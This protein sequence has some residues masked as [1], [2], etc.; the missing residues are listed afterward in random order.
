MT[1]QQAPSNP[2][3][4]GLEIAIIGMAGR[5]PGAQS[6]AEFWQNLQHSVESIVP[7]EDAQLLAQGVSPDTLADPNYV[8][9]GGVLTDPDQFDA[10]FFGFSPR[11]A[12][13]L[14]PQQR[15]FLE[16]AWEAL[17]TAGYDTERYKGSIGVY[18]GAGM[19]GYLLNL[20]AN[21]AIRETVSPYELF[22]SNDKDFLT[23]RVSY[24]LN[25]QGPSLDVQTACSSSL[26]AVHLACQGL[27]SGECDMALA[28]GVA[29][30]K[31]LGY[32]A[33]TGG[34]YA[35]DGHCRAFDA[36][37]GG[38]VGGNGV[39]M[40]V[41][42]RLEDA[43]ADGD[44]IDAVI[45]GSAINNDGALKVS[46]TAPRIDA[47]A[48]VIQAALSV[49]EVPPESIG[50][51]EA[52]GTGTDLGDPIEVAALT[53][54]F[55]T[56]QSGFCAIGSV[57]TNIGHLDAAAGIAGLIKTVLALKHRQIPASLHFQQPNPKID[58]ENSPFYVNTTLA[59]WPRKDGS[60]RAGVSSFGIG[61]TNAHVILE[62]APIPSHR[63]VLEQPQLLI[64]SAKT[65][66][67]LAAA[68]HALSRYLE[69]SPNPDLANVAYTLQVG[70][71]AFNHRRSV[72]CQ[73][74][75]EAIGQLQLPI[76]Q[77]ISQTKFEHPT[78][79]FLFP[80]QGSQYPGMAQGLYESQP[81]FRD[82]LNECATLLETDLDRPLLEIICIQGMQNKVG[83]AL[84]VQALHATPLPTTHP[85]LPPTHHPLS[86]TRYTQPALFAI[87]Y[88]LAKLWMHWGLK[89]E[90]MLG[91]SL[92]E[93]VAA[94]LAGVFDLE[95]A[96]RL[97]ALRGRL[98]QQ[99]PGGY[100]LSV[101]ISSETLQPW[102]NDEITLAASNGPQLCV[103]SGGEAEIATLQTQLEE[104]SVSC[105]R[106]HTSH[107]F[108]SPLMEPMRA[109]F[110]EAVSQVKLHPP[111]LPFISNVTGTWIT[112]EE[113]T[114][115]AYW[116][117][118]ARQTVRFSEGVTELLQLADPVLL[119]VGPG[120]TLTTL[121]RQHLAAA[122]PSSTIHSL[123]HPKAAT[124]EDADIKQLL[125]A[126]GQ[127]WSTGISIDWQVFQT[128]HRRRIPLP[129]Y[130]FERQR[131]WVDLD[132][133][134]LNEASFNL[135]AANAPQ[136]SD[137]ALA[138]DPA[139]WFYSPG[140]RRMT[141][142]KPKPLPPMERPCWLIFL[143]NLGIGEQLAKQIEQ[144]GQD[145][146]TVRSGK[147]FEQIGYRQF[148]L[149]CSQPDNYQLLLDDLQMRET[150][151]TAIVYLWSLDLDQP[152]MALLNLL[153]TWSTQ[154]DPLQVT[155]VTEAVY[156]VI[157]HETLQPE[158]S[159]IQG[160][161]QVI[162]QEYPQIGCRQIDMLAPKTSSEIS[163][164]QLAP[165]LWQDLQT[166]SPPA[167]VA[168]RGRHR[169]EQTYQAVPL[170]ERGSERGPDGFRQGGVYA[171]IGDLEQGLG[172]AWARALA[173]HYRAKLVLI[174]PVESVPAE[175]TLLLEQ[176]A[177]EVLTLLVDLAS[178]DTLQNALKQAVNEVGPIHGIFL[179]SPTTN[180]KSAAPIALLQSF[181]WHY[182]HQT[183]GQVLENL[184]IALKDVNC[185]P[186][187]CCIQSSLSSVIG[188][189]GLAA[190]AGANHMIDTLVTQQN[191]QSPFP[192]FSVNWDAWS[193]EAAETGWGSTLKDF[194]LTSQEVWTA[195]ERILTQANPG[196]IV[197][198]KG[199]LQA[200]L[201]K[202]IHATPHI[203]THDS[204]SEGSGTHSRPQLS[205]AYV[206]PRNDVEQTI[207]TIW[208]DLLGLEQVGIH[209]SFFDL[210]GHSL[211]AIQVISRLRE[212]FPV[213]LEMRNL[214]FEAPTVAGIAAMIAE[215]I[216]QTEDLDTM[217][218]LLA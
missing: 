19:N 198:S 127:L 88:A 144:A 75:T 52:H 47:Q 105:R 93:Y 25:L 155:V 153:K 56:D 134:E 24:K 7:L 28:G 152:F 169:W 146:F 179:S 214:L 178:S 78:L 18:G 64:L 67:A 39:G 138:A 208:Q 90:A 184:V 170:P 37:A 190:Y 203:D 44:T 97:V 58:F 61:G 142:S 98:M 33:Q 195:T 139:N 154:S 62:A 108:H 4:T 77:A 51:I 109:P 173:Q 103:V 196:Q 141:A 211:L 202:W 46:Y 166:V 177:T 17:E 20:Y 54:A 43:L 104:N 1:S 199:D 133:S 200:R 122:A 136:P 59:D 125:T 92:G 48:A 140:W 207:A 35:A 149:D 186:D 168:Y 10:A 158:H 9:V 106:L 55:Q 95:T 185:A 87:E 60:R 160:L 68:A 83:N 131:Y 116:G 69:R 137:I 57:K 91:H 111:T 217:A 143:D 102:I 14:D 161:C 16:T 40:V 183:K 80:G 188:G 23:T 94:C 5:F 53:Q 11:E 157:G 128:E 145:V 6:V 15:V 135:N 71:R 31:Q 176:G 100:M 42:K 101:G 32:R 74:T 167:V 156:E 22:I 107:A 212:A 85:P 150:I 118:Q 148:S 114:N 210:G 124:E 96:L 163:S 84:P 66:T 73:N 29:I 180:E 187:F 201:A 174:Q 79:I 50:Y 89:P 121:T 218:A 21:P 151:P 192:W 76:S 34:I 12:E 113:A 126:A 13:L 119:E 171:I 8:K 30:S 41:L 129:T 205:T 72:V 182:N 181:H 86:Q 110:V 193:E 70:R 164:A 3:L 65:A 194:A 197:V 189:V 172:L 81:V 147:S 215:Q 175:R 45:K 206:A 209:D 159:A 216:P 112:P 36:L 132:F 117:Q 38:T 49:A 26:V 115:P 63:E 2:P 99:R 130:P 120:R 162:S 213:D 27:L 165:M 191:Q 82:A 204:G 123:P